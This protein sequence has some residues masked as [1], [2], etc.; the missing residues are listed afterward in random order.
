MKGDVVNSF[1]EFES[2]ELAWGAY[3]KVLHE[4]LVNLGVSSVCE[5]G[6]GANPAVELDFIERHRLKYTL[7]DISQHEMDKAPSGYKT[8]CANICNKAELPG[9]RFDFVFTKMLA[10]HVESGKDFHQN[11][12]D[13][14]APGGYAFHY[15]PTLFAPPFLINRFAPE[16]LAGAALDVFSPR[17]KVRRAKFPAY[18]SWCYGPTKSQIS[19]FQSIG[20]EVVSYKG[21]FG[22]MRYYERVPFGFKISKAVAEYLARNPVPAFTS[23]AQVLLRKPEV[24]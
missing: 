12:F 15:F 11:V 2:S 23:F 16:R 1:V 22:A 9:E 7:L 13:L 3:P 21:F 19:K 14:L 18:Y 6:G 20:Y 8:V 17:D 5:V 24:E 4:N 10:E